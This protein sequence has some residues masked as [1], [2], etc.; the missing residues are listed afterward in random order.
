MDDI[1]LTDLITIIN[2][3]HDLNNVVT[4][5]ETPNVKAF[6]HGKRQIFPSKN[7]QELTSDYVIM[8]DENQEVNASSKI[9]IQE[10]AG[11]VYTYADKE[12]KILS[13]GRGHSQ[14]RNHVEIWV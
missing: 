14:M 13:Y 7:G 1:Y 6:V 9:K 5:V 10:I 3:T 12:Y 2:E 8:L 4:R 11:R